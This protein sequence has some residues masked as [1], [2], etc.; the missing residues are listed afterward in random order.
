MSY[1]CH[2]R[3]CKAQHGVVIPGPLKS[4]T[5]A[6]IST[7]V[8]PS[9]IRNIFSFSCYNCRRRSHTLSLDQGA[10]RTCAP[11]CYLCLWF[12]ASLLCNTSS[13]NDY[14]LNELGTT[15]PI[16]VMT[17]FLRSIWYQHPRPRT[18]AISRPLAHTVRYATA[19]SSIPT[20]PRQ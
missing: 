16:G 5:C 6:R 4:A 20:L 9:L 14:D 19:L 17:L 2:T 12:L 13:G 1:R 15:L 3:Y 10:R 18:L 8:G 11:F 7:T